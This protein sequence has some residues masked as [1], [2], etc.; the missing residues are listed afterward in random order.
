MKVRLLEKSKNAITL[1][2]V[3]SS[4]YKITVGPDT[5]WIWGGLI[6]Q[7]TMSST[8]DPAIMFVFGEKGIKGSDDE[9][10]TKNYQIR[11]VKNGVEIDRLTITSQELNYENVTNIGNK[12]M[13]GVDDIISLS[14]TEAETCEPIDNTLY[15]VWKNNTFKKTTEVVAMTDTISG[16]DS[17]SLFDN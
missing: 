9:D 3:T 17:C 13:Q 8:A 15:V 14:L 1:N 4:F 11:A 12:G 10:A 7:K 16:T 6:S 2:G 5:G